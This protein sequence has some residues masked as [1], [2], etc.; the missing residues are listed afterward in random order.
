MKT[1]G[2]PTPNANDDE[3]GAQDEEDGGA[4]VLVR[5]V[6]DA[7]KAKVEVDGMP[8]VNGDGVDA[9]W[10]VGCEAAGLPKVKVDEGI[11]GLRVDDDAE[12]VE[13]GATKA[14]AAHN[15]GG[16]KN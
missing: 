5:R 1:P 3:D 15:S 13:A 2:L 7:E 12:G 6:E 16:V 9:F 11:V 10:V 8:K 4:G 14:V